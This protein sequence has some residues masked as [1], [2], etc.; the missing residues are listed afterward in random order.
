MATDTV[1]GVLER[2][3]SRF[4]FYPLEIVDL[5][6][7]S[8]S[9]N[10]LL[11]SPHRVQVINFEATGNALIVEQMSPKVIN[12]RL[13]EYPKFYGVRNDK[14]LVLDKRAIQG[15][16]LF[17]GIGTSLSGHWFCSEEFKCATES[18]ARTFDFEF[19]REE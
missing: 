7:R 5:V 4:E 6:N 12:G 18:F 10:W 16:H 8:T 17:S 11:H 19:T 1:K 15:L 2:L 13:V 9:K 14:D 3:D